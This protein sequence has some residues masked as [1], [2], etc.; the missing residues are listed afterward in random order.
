M[1]Q[2]GYIYW[3][4]SVTC[5]RGQE[6]T[7]TLHNSTVQCKCTCAIQL[8]CKAWHP[9]HLIELLEILES[10]GFI[11]VKTE[12]NDTQLFQLPWAPA[13]YILY[14]RSYPSLRLCVLATSAK[15]KTVVQ[16][17]KTYWKTLWRFSQ[18]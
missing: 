8:H 14:S 11:P 15:S 3:I 16:E 4:L 2:A 6:A 5:S 7:M 13:P 17:V 10:K 9:W 18:G 12:P 1:S